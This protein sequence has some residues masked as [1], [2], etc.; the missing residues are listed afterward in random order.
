MTS[1]FDCIL[2]AVDMSPASAQV[3][4]RAAMLAMKHGAPL[5][6]MDIGP[7]SGPPRLPAA[8]ALKAL[9]SSVVDGLGVHAEVLPER[10]TRVSDIAEFTGFSRRSLVVLKHDRRPRLRS[11]WRGSLAEQ[12]MRVCDGPVL[13][14]KAQPN[15]RENY[16]RLLVAVDLS[17]SAAH[18][19]ALA[20][21]LGENSEVQVLHA[22]RPLHSNP[23]RDAE[24]PDRI[25]RAYLA[26][27]KLEAHE[28]LLRV[29]AGA[30]RHHGGVTTVLRDGDPAWHATLQQSHAKADLVVVGKR[31]SS[32]LPDILCGGVAKRILAWCEADILVVPC[33]PPDANPDAKAAAA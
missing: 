5:K 23:L 19:M 22:I 14:L 26:R 20:C 13:I 9:V 3:I 15:A 28:Q 21:R 27:R 30:G 16:E 24:M 2:A 4:H 18:L 7:L 1:G 31:R 12:L 11:L 8:I 10:A 25:L 33:H 29:A 17:A 32:A 6:V